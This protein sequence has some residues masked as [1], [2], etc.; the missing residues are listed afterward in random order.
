MSLG[1]TIAGPHIES[2][3]IYWELGNSE[4]KFHVKYKAEKTLPNLLKLKVC[5]T[6]TSSHNQQ[7]LNPEC[8]P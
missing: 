4:D 1:L 5:G 3:P 7:D 8:S 2:R 6:A